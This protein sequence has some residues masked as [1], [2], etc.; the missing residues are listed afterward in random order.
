MDI[1]VLLKENISKAIKD[2][3]DVEPEKVMI[4]HPDNEKWGDYATN[5][6]LEIAKTLKQT[7]LEIAKN[8][9]YK[10]EK[11][12]IE[13]ERGGKKYPVF[14]KIET[15]PPGF[16]NFKLS[17]YW[18]HN[19]L[20]N[21]L[22]NAK[23]YG[24]SDFGD[25]KT[26][27]VEYSQ[28]NP[29]KPMHIGHARNNF[30]GS[31][32][33]NILSFSGY[34]T[35]QLNYMNDWGTHICKSMLMYKKY[36][37]GREPDRKPDH[38]VGEF[39]KMYEQESSENKEL[40]K[41]LDKEL[42]ELFISLE[43][44]DPE[45][46]ELWKKIVGW[47]YE[48]WE[49]TYNDHNVK[50]D[51]WM[52]QSDYKTSGKE[53]VEI[54]V[55]KG[56]AEKDETGAV[57]ARLEKYDIPDK[58][59]LRSDG[60]SVYST[61]DLQMAKDSYERYKFDKRLYVVDFRQSDYF[62]QIFKILEVLGFDWAERLHHVAYGVVKLPEGQMSSRKGLVVNADDVFQ[63]LIE[64]ET[65]EV[66]KNF[67]DV[68]EAE[69]VAK[70]V[71][72]AAFRYGM[73]KV[74]SSQDIIFDYSSVTKFDGNTGPYLQYTYART[75][76]I[77]ENA[78]YSGND[79]IPYD[80]VDPEYFNYEVKRFAD[81]KTEP[82]EE[83]VLRELYKFPE[84]VHK[85]AE[86]FSPHVICNYLFNLAQKYNAMYANL[87]VINADNDDDKRI[88]LLITAAVGVVIKNGLSLLGIETVRRM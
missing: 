19:I 39:Y 24:S 18:L 59:L 48:G 61:Q 64:L 15:A 47:A 67:E 66:G 49:K 20:Y 83:A 3:Y 50:F 35:V 82:Q 60:T 87:P 14:E 65:E 62:K 46:I 88:R 80:P 77:L 78:R 6:S 71:A 38:F 5:V 55:E 8:V 12:S 4:E 79:D 33:S 10:L 57:I 11:M 51:D 37:E 30:L 72:L 86:N 36:G 17:S 42:A 68:Q 31:S 84:E 40:D 25:S 74:D 45:T 27:V 7:P 29:N 16:I 75:S 41:E 52:Y 76:S 2:L 9:C 34:K 73:L 70:K 32:I 44:G 56:I 63:K 21:V 58:V 22:E 53:I 26:V 43:K 1:S 81:R 54:A 13:F 28:P 69:D 85:A 23:D